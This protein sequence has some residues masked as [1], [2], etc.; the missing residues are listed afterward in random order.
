[1]PGPTGLDDY[2]TLVPLLAAQIAPGGIAAIEIGCDQGTA[3]LALLA[4]AGPR[5]AH[6][7]RSRRP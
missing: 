5:R 4:D 1:M 2:R 6:R 7:P 3:V